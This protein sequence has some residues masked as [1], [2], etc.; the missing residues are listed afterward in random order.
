MSN[1]GTGPAEPWGRLRLRDTAPPHHLTPKSLMNAKFLAEVYQSRIQ[2]HGNRVKK[3]RART[4]KA[5]MGH[6]VNLQLPIS[7][8]H[9]YYYNKVLTYYKGSEAQTTYRLSSPLAGLLQHR[10]RLW[11]DVGFQLRG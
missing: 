5:S 7:Y 6:T 1:Y 3:T 11:G 8:I 10:I 4:R 2:E 9:K